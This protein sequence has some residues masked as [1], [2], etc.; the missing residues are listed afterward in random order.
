MSPV[1]RGA[2]VV[3]VFLLGCGGCAR[4]ERRPSVILISIDT[5]RA[6]HVS[7]RATPHIDAV[8]RDAIVFR[9]AWSHSPLTLPSH[10]SM[11]TGL[12]PP[13]HG[14]RDNAGYRF[15][16][17]A[18]PTLAGLLRANGYRTGAAVSAYVLR[19]A[20]GV[21]SGFDDFD[22]AIGIIDGAPLGAL[23]RS[24]DVTE[25]IAEKW[26]GAQD[27]KPF[28]FFL[29]LYEPHTPYM[30][31]Y[32]AD[33]AHAD[34]IVGKFLD[35]LRT[36]HLYD[37]AIVVLVADHGEGLMDHGEQ[38]HGVLLYRESLQVPLIVKPAGAHDHREVNAPVG[39]IGVT[40]T[41]LD[42]AGVAAPRMTGHSLVATRDASPV[43]SESLY[44]RI[45]LGC[46][47]LRSIVNGE[48]HIIDGAHAEVYDTRRDPRERIN[49]IDR[50]R[51]A[52]ASARSAIAQVAGAF[53]SPGAIDA[54]EAKKLA[55]LGY[56]SAGGDSGSSSRDPRECL[57]DLARL[58]EIA[59]WNAQGR[60]GDAIA[61]LEA[62]LA[63]NPRWSDVRDQLGAAYDESGDHVR[64]ARL[65]EDGIRATPRLAGAF[66]LSAASSLFDAHQLDDAAA[67]AHAAETS[68]PAAAHLLLGEIAL[69]R[70][71]PAAAAREQKVA[72]SFRYNRGHA[73]FLAARIAAAQHDYAR[74]LD[75]LKA[76]EQ[77]CREAGESLP[78]GFH[79]AAGDAL[80]H[81]G[82]TADAER[83]FETEIAADPHD[84][85]PYADLA[86][87]QLIRHDR[88]AALQ[89]IDRMAAA[90]P[91]RDTFVF[92]A[93]S[94]DRWG[95]HEAA[96]KWRRRKE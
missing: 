23:Q 20:T 4:R 59:G 77:A 46:G 63:A 33:V 57:G 8:A 40:P 14:V 22:D 75:L 29:H 47:E 55:A 34:A 5:L 80:A 84:V 18:H 58:K 25:S 35:F 28:F 68:D 19:G 48:R 73:L 65:Y 89:T 86:L 94:L 91:S 44:A 92:A 32:E 85:Q 81:V 15:D 61:G 82:R 62:M 90:N 45:H 36:R 79:Y 12:L 41:I 78:R 16:A 93:E 26:I 64:A 21:A 39:L 43:Y 42:L 96:A 66:S 49:L 13:E 60:R 17:A 72:A 83:E 53:V 11:L 31:S 10:L 54:E 38:E 2:C 51:R 7:P 27:G 87:L 3:L 37:D 88:A 24:G 56:V 9:N 67:H 30:P 71:D 50:E 6:D 74:A 1:R 95:E 70:N 69:A 52:Y 76:A